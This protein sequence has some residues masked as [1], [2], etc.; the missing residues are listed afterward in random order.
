MTMASSPSWGDLT[1]GELTGTSVA[2]V[3]DDQDVLAVLDV[4]RTTGLRHVVVVDR[5]G[6][7]VAV[8]S[9]RLGVECAGMD[10]RQLQA[11][12]VRDLVLDRQARIAPEQPV[13]DAATLAL[14]HSAGALAVTD[15]NGQVLGIVTGADLLRA[16]VDSG[17]DGDLGDEDADD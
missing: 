1:V 5:A 9:D 7:F 12:R 3:R 14:R 8:L 6:E 16:L 2:T 11:T 15:P 4:L 13:R 17:A 10:R